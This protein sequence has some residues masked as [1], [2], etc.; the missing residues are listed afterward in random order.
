MSQATRA[1]EESIRRHSKSF[2]LA[3][4]LLPT[5]ARMHA[6]A[7]YAWCRRADDAVDLVEPAEQGAALATLEAELESIYAGEP[8]AD[9]ILALFQRAVSERRV[10]VEYPLELLEGMRMD[11]KGHRYATLDELLLYCHRVA[12]VVGLMMCHVM[13]VRGDDALR[14][15]AHLG[16]AMQLTNICRDVE[17]D[18]GRGRLYLPG[19]LLARH[20]C[21]GL[22]ERLGDP[23]PE[24]ARA[25]AS[26]ATED[27]LAEAER[28][29]ASGDAGLPALSWRCAL[30]IRTARHVYSSIGARVRASGCDPLAGRA[31]V[32]LTAKLLLVG[33]A[34]AAAVAEAPR[35]LLAP[36][37][38]PALPGRVARFPEDILPI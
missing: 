26:A 5:D 30:A 31:F 13:G 22:R 16:I 15:A 2:S 25:P 33:R 9:P 11:V 10:P 1:S 24:S 32:P 3:S 4:R 21:A 29:Y 20:G 7:V 19:D 38:R 6:V 37:G 18:W 23:F 17:E 34:L 35:R 8:Q 14:N 28:Y 12:G 36:A 27:L